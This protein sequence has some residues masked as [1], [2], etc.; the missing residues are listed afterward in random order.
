MANMNNMDYKKRM[1]SWQR[2]IA[3]RTEAFL[4]YAVSNATESSELLQTQPLR[5]FPKFHRTEIR[6]GRLLGQG[7]F[8]EVRRI[9]KIKLRDEYTSYNYDEERAR[10]VQALETASRGGFVVKHL[11]KAL[12][13]NRK[14]FYHAAT[15]LLLE[16]KFLARFDHP[17]IIKIH[18]WAIGEEASYGVGL[19]DGYFIYLIKLVRR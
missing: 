14:R 2:S 19:H 16:A 1:T 9:N 18:G 15:D 8:S 10:Q 4:E 6:V 11:S 12:A 3:R 5:S 13:S 7:A 17:N